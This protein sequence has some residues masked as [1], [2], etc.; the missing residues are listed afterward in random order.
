MCVGFS[1]ATSN[2]EKNS[3]FKSPDRVGECMTV[4]Q[5]LLKLWQEEHH[6]LRTSL[7]CVISPRIIVRID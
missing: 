3:W 7:P 1:V 4:P 5:A 2:W 6:G